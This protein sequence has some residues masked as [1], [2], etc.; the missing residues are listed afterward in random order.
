VT[1]QLIA[2]Y[3]RFDLPTTLAQLDVDIRLRDQVERVI[4]HTLR[5]GESIHYLPISLTPAT[6]WSALEKVEALGQ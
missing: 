6:L 3:K 5:P 4:H 1:K 2:A